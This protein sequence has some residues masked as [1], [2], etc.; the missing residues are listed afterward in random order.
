MPSCGGRGEELCH[1]S[2]V[3]AMYASDAVGSGFMTMLF[4]ALPLSLVRCR[5][6]QV[7]WLHGCGIRDVGR[8]EPATLDREDSSRA[9]SARPQNSNGIGSDWWLKGDVHTA[10]YL[11]LRFTNVKSVETGNE[12]D[13]ASRASAWTPLMA[14]R[15]T[16]G[17]RR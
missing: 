8:T 5:I 2:L 16:N 15:G 11:V 14:Q 10:G 4:T 1:L 3:T 17:G 9:V 7:A 6:N 13:G 12:F